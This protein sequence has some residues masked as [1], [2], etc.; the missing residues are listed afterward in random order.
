MCGKSSKRGVR[1]I[2]ILLVLSVLALQPL[3][4]WAW[5]SWLTGDAKQEVQLESTTPVQESKED[6]KELILSLEQYINQLENQLIEQKKMQETL[7]KTLEASGTKIADKEASA[8]SLLTELINLRS[9]LEIS[10]KSYNVL[11]NDYDALKAEYDLKVSESNDYFKAL[12]DSEA[13]LGAI[14][15][16]KWGGTIGASALLDPSESKY[17]VGLTMGVGYDSWSLL[18]GAD[19]YIPTGFSLS[20]FDFKDLDYRAGLQFDF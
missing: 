12:A 2:V 14:D 19:Y 20:G 1:S 9:S 16:S 13:E 5:P 17:G 15:D 8:E 4:A 6:Q 10:E 11:K 3:A 7:D 18:V